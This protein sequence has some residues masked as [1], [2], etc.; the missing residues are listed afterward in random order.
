MQK[1]IHNKTCHK[2]LAAGYS[3]MAGKRHEERLRYLDFIVG[4]KINRMTDLFAALR[5]ITY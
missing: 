5:L 4:S 3:I 1:S 2:V